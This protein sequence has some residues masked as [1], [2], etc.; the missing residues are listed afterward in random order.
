MYQKIR[1]L[2]ITSRPISWINTA[3]P[4]AAGYLVVERHVTWVLI[5]GTIFFLIPYNLLVYG[6][7]DVFDYESD[8]LNPRKGGVEGAVL[9]RGRHRLVLYA[10]V[11]SCFPFVVALLWTGSFF[12]KLWL[13]YLLFMAVAYSAPR[14]RFKE[15]PFLDSFTSATHF[16]GPLVYAFLLVGWHAADW[17]YVL[18]F[19][20]WAMA[21]HA[22]GAVQDVIADRKAGIGSVATVT[23]AA[24]T[25]RLSVSLYIISAGLL[26]T[27]MNFECD[28]IALF[29]LL[30]VA[31]I[32]P[33]VMLKDADA[34][35]AHAGWKRFLILNQ[36]TGAAVT[37]VLIIANR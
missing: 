24:W 29:V 36:L 26:A 5:M 17:P 10:A 15:R 16:V 12:S 22:F 30:Y 20:L 13:L 35:Q 28:I 19:F 18:T 21:S 1:D 8:L 3:Y 31:S 33:Y 37:I 9:D 23:G 4:F 7:N 2:L 32:I 6:V 34:E 14:L 11:G 27:K 25:T